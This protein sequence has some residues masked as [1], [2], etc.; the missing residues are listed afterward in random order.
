MSYGLV[1]L[2]GLV[3]SVSSCIAV[4][5]G[6]LVAVAAK[7]NEAT[8]AHPG[9]QRLKSLIYFNAG[10]IVSYI[11]LGGVIGA[12]GSA[13]TLSNEVNGALTIL[14]S[15]VMIFFGM[16]MLKLIP[17]FGRFLPGMPKLFGDRVH[18]L[19]ARDVKSGAF[20]LGA[21]TFFLPCGFT[22]A[23]QLYVLAKGSFA[24]GALTMLAF[25]LGT[26]PALL[27]LSAM[28]SFAR[29]AFQRHFLKIAGVA[30]IVLG[31]L[32]IQYGAVLTGSDLVASLPD[33]RA[34]AFVAERDGGNQIAV[35]RI[36]GLD[37]VPNRF[38]VTQG[39]PVEWRIDASEAAACGR[40]L[41]A[42]RLGIRTLLSANSTSTVKFTPADPGDFA[43]NCGMGM[44]TPGSTITVVAR[45]NG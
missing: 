43:F 23:L 12:L 26:L 30:V 37:Y 39:V 21:A 40:I 32:N 16:Q 34:G 17:P 11:L 14:A 29:G 6:L 36:V 41:L 38:T 4:T 31:L 28:S 20:T 2:I 19:A 44:M 15:A 22:Q 33:T 8:A 27:S 10:R 5:G 7:Y 18:D 35:M 9:L 45:T 1:F 13:L 25:S 24:V 3:A 42:P